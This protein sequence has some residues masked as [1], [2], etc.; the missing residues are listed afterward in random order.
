MAEGN[1]RVAES[2]KKGRESF[3]AGDFTDAREAFLRVLALDES[4]ATARSYLDRI[5]QELA[6]P[7]AGLDLSKKSPQRDILDEEMAESAEPLDLDEAEEPKTGKVEGGTRLRALPGA[8]MD[9]RFLLALGGA[10][11]LAVAVGGYLLL[12]PGPGRLDR[13][14]GA[15]AARPSSTRPCSSGRARVAETVAEL[16]QIPAGHPDHARAQK[17]LASLTRE[18]GGAAP[19]PGDAC[20][21]PRRARS[22]RRR[23]PAPRRP[24]SSAPRP[25]GRSPRSDTSTR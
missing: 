10:L 25:R 4:D 11:V 24:C 18:A 15:R 13:T 21:D 22:R 8:R 16:R 1:R 14:A 3:E 12:R 19:S 7:S 2:L 23:R 17:L 5:E 6:R 9:K 20:G